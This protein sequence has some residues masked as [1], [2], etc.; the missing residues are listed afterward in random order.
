MTYENSGQKLRVAAGS[1][2]SDTQYTVRASLLIEGGT[3]PV[4]S[5]EAVFKTGAAP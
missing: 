5:I 1:W 3:D 2:Q 4:D